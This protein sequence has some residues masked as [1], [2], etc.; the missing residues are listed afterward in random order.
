ML[1]RSTL[2]VRILVLKDHKANFLNNPIVRLIKP[3]KNEL[4]RI[5]KAILQKINKRLRTRLKDFYPQIKEELLNKR[6]RFVQEYIDIT[7]KDR[8]IL[9][10]VRK[11]LL[12][13]EKDI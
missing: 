9:Y 13:D 6:L 1:D 7:S 2:S 3:V 11:S 10:H 5:S 4:E 12:F 8:E